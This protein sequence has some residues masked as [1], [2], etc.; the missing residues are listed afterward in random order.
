[1]LWRR[2][3]TSPQCGIGATDRAL[4]ASTNGLNMDFVNRSSNP[5]F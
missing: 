4:E 3:T 2:A 1:M 5:A